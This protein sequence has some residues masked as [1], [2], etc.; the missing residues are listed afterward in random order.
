[1]M[2]PSVSIA[3]P[4]ALGITIRIGLVGQLSL[5]AATAAVPRLDRAGA[6]QAAASSAR[7]CRRWTFRIIVLYSAETSLSLF[8]AL[9]LA[10]TACGLR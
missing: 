4:G 3:L 1:M 9:V 2:R 5:P 7:L 10:L 6:A 8:L